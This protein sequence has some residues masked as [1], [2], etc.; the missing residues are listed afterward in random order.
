MRKKARKARQA[1]FADEGEYQHRAKEKLDLIYEEVKVQWCPFQGHGRGM[2]APRVDIGVGP[3]AIE[4]QYG[5]R[6]TQ[7]LVESR[8]FINPIIQ[9]HNHNVEETG[10]R[11]SFE[12]IVHFNENA[13]CLLCIEIEDTN[14]KKHCLGNLVNA[15][16]LGRIGLLVARSDKAMRTFLRQRVYLRFLASVG[17]NS[18]KTDNALVLT[19]EQFDECLE[20]PRP[21]AAAEARER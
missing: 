14:S 4:Q 20:I 15:S 8:R 18:F 10:E 13:R 6:Y 19:A 2:Y 17:K 21:N 9:M 3:F 5:D 7:L 12:E 1:R 11:T 16:A